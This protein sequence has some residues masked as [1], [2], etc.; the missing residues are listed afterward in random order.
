MCFIEISIIK[1]IQNQLP[2]W[3]IMICAFKIYFNYDCIG[4]MIWKA[5]FWSLFGGCSFFFHQTK[6]DYYFSRNPPSATNLYGITPFLNSLVPWG[7]QVTDPGGIHYYLQR[8][9]GIWQEEP[10]LRKDSLQFLPSGRQVLMKSINVW[11]V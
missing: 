10:A 8:E 4:S 11:N 6:L 9:Y 1:G 7:W 5:L 3:T 2:I